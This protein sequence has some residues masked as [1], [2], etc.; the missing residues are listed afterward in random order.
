MLL[1]IANIYSALTMCQE[2]S[3]GALYRNELILI[4]LD[5][6]KPGPVAETVHRGRCRDGVK[7]FRM[8]VRMEVLSQGLGLTE[9]RFLPVELLEV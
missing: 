1:L 4:D 9:C 2:L 7:D 6:G 5:K 3:R 8:A